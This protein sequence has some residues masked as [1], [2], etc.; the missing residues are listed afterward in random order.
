[1]LKTRIF[2]GARWFALG[3]LVL[4]DG[5]S[6]SNSPLLDPAGPI[7]RSE[8]HLI[9]IAF[10]LMLIPVIPVIVMTF[11][12][13]RR[14]RASNTNATYKPNWAHSNKIELVVWMI[15]ILIVV[16]LSVLSWI[17][18]HKLN[19]YKRLVVKQ[20]GVAVKSL[21][22]DVIALNWK[23]LFIYPEQHLATVN[24]MV[25]PVGTPLNIHLTSDTVMTSFFIPRLGTQIYAM[26]G[27]MTRLNLLASRAGTFTGLNTQIS[28]VGFSK[29]HF[30]V[31]A[32]KPQGFATWVAKVHRSPKQL[33]F[34]AYR[35]LEKPSLV[36]PVTY[37]SDVSPNTL[38]SDVI[39][40]YTQGRKLTSAQEQLALRSFRSSH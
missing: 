33:D 26:A 22:I 7:G 25:I 35:K 28:G 11:W 6:L 14:Y 32:M 2:K 9:V 36:N 37:Y 23:W 8:M 18:T 40:K 39:A 38:F 15:P 19:P 29:M 20:N 17:T 10:L 34:A 3:S 21:P 5:C 16:G 4:L 27:M 24:Q 12:F 1:M 30:K 13:A 31:I